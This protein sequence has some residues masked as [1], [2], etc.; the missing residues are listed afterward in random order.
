[1]AKV[2][3]AQRYHRLRSIPGVGQDPGAGAAVRDPRHRPLPPRAGVSVL[4]A[5]GAVSEQ[6]RPAR[7]GHGGKKIGNAHLKWAFCEAAVLFLRGNPEGQRLRRAAAKKH[8]KGKALSI[9]AAHLGRAVYTMLNR[10]VPFD[11]AV[12]RTRRLNRRGRR[13]PPPNW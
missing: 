4:R 9:L 10:R 2:H 12:L 3:D 7:S 5:A 6:R 8:G 11:Q 1:M 13:S